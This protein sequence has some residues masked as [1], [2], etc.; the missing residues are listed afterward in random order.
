MTQEE[1]NTY[2]YAS[3][4]SL[5]ERYQSGDLEPSA[6][7]DGLISRVEEVNPAINAVAEK[8]YDTAREKASK[9][10]E[11]YA[12][13][14]NDH[15]TQPLLGV[16]VILKEKHQL[17][18]HPVSQGVKE[19]ETVPDWNHPIVERILQAGG[20][21]LVRSTTPEFCSATVTESK[22]W[23]TTVNPW[24]AEKTPG[25]SSGGSGA[26]LAS[27]FAPVA[28]GSDI[29]GST[30]IPSA[31]CGVVG[32]KAPYGVVPGLHPSTMDWYRSDSAMARSV[33]DVRLLHNVIAGQHP[34][35]QLSVPFRPVPEPAD[36]TDLHDVTVLVST[37]VGDYPTQRATAENLMEA[38]ESLR[39]LGATVKEC[40]LPWHAE[41]IMDLAFAHYGHILGPLT[42]H[43]IV[44]SHATVSPYIHEWIER[45]QEA[46]DAMPLDVTLSKESVMRDQLSAV[47][48]GASALL[49]PVSAIDS[50][51]CH[52]PVNS[53]GQCGHFYWQDQIALPFN[54]NNRNPSL[55]VPSGFGPERVPTGLQIVGKPYDEASVFR[56]GYGLEITHPWGSAHP[57]F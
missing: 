2:A 57:K 38:A 47:M 18:G 22:M 16:P 4:E 12:N 54:I 35:D 17:A 39:Q 13:G 1:S 25:G 43:D 11:S 49:C 5:V 15:H 36:K 32:Y 44:R 3:A 51:G 31:Y 40:Q 33:G 14:K 23:G 45:A 30:R 46:A 19:L 8:L 55:A 34:K 6:V 29:G 41:E 52:A 10:D 20:V 56:I 42:L 9:A 50:M 28:T 7:I 24:N 53:V 21:P 37:T 26:C 48:D 27:G